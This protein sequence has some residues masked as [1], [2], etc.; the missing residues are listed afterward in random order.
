M[1]LPFCIGFS[2]DDVS[3]F[4]GLH[5]SLQLMVRILPSGSLYLKIIEILFYYQGVTFHSAYEVSWHL[6]VLCLWRLFFQEMVFWD[7]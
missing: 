1:F 7:I 6:V 3:F 5:I 2:F 4:S